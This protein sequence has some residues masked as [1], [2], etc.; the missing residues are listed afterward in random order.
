MVGSAAAAEHQQV[1]AADGAARHTARPAPRDRHRRARS[2]CRVRR[3]W[4]ARRSPQAAD[5][6]GPP[7]TAGELV[8]EVG[9]VGAVDHV[10]GWC[11]VRGV[12][13][14]RDRLRQTLPTRQ[15]AV[16]LDG[17]RDCDGSPSTVAARHAYGLADMGHGDCRDHFGAR[18]QRRDLLGMGSPAPPLRSAALRASSRRCAGR[19]NRSGRRLVPWPRA[20]TPSLAPWPCRWRRPGPRPR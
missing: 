4:S 15:A 13:D 5:A 3:G 16:G 9:R 2:P 14:R 18:S 19:R 11:A 20:A 17:K 1:A 8:G 10:V 7:A 6:G 12:V